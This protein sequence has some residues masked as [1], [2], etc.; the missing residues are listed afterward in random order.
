[1]TPYQIINGEYLFG[2]SEAQHT[3]HL[4]LFRI[5]EIRLPSER[6]YL[7]DSYFFEGKTKMMLPYSDLIHKLP[8]EETRDLGLF[9]YSRKG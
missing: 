4:R 5:G 3:K 8:E 9:I 7:G 1:M 6:T 2:V